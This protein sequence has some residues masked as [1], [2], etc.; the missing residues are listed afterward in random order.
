MAKA[1]IQ[2]ADP[3]P[4]VAEVMK[5]HRM[6]TGMSQQQL[7]SRAG[8]SRWTVTK[9]EQGKRGIGTSTIGKLGKVLGRDFE[10]EML[11]VLSE[12]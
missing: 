9:I 1:D 8:I 2:R 11:G 10:H 6:A 5:A 4:L 7:A 12:G 3:N